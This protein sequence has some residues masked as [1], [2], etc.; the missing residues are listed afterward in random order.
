[1]GILARVPRCIVSY[2]DTDGVRHTIEGPGGQPMSGFGLN[3][4]S[5]S[6]YVGA[7]QISGRARKLRKV[8]SLLFGYK[9]SS[10]AIECA[11][12]NNS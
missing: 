3:W 9:Q 12:Q 2:L 6:K 10:K 8:L 4:V 5:V 11:P 7:G 1:M